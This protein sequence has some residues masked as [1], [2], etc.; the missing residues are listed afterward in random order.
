VRATASPGNRGK[1]AARGQGLVEFALILPVLL[2]IM[3]A[4]LDFGRAIYAYSVV[5]NCAREGARYASV[6]PDDTAG[7]LNTAR[8]A[9]IALDPAQLSVVVSQPTSDTVRVSVRYSFALITP[10]VASATGRSPIV[11]TSASTMYIGY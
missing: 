3:L 4:I 6:A 2:L 10:F 5:S 8:G 1:R 11:L 7:I 9:G